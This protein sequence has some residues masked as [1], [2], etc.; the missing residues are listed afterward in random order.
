[1]R[2]NMCLTILQACYCF[3]LSDR[4]VQRYPKVILTHLRTCRSQKK[5]NCGTDGKKGF[6]FTIHTCV[7]FS[8]IPAQQQ[9]CG[10]QRD[11]VEGSERKAGEGENVRE[12][13]ETGEREGK[14]RGGKKDEVK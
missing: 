14:A 13:D 11:E 10:A 12:G 7:K 1:M 5:K 8:H 6:F 3:C 4:Y 2:E 9:L